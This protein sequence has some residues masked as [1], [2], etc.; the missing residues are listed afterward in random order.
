MILADIK[1][2]VTDIEGTTS[3]IHFVHQVLFPY[4]KQ[5][6]AD[7]LA[8]RAQEPAIQSQLHAV[9]AHTNW[10]DFEVNQA[11]CLAQIHDILQTWMAEDQ[12]IGALKALQGILWAEGYARGEFVTHF[13]PDA[14]VCLK[15]WFEKDLL[16]AVYSSRSV[17]AQQLLFGHTAQGDIQPWFSAWFDTAVGG[18]REVNAYVNIYQD[19]HQQAVN[20]LPENI[21]FLSDIAQELD[22]A[23]AAGWQTAHLVREG[24]HAA[25]STHWQCQSFAEIQLA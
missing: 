5:N 11:A 2:I 21:L 14:L 25:G 4:A 8:R 16:L 15:Q 17:Q 10:L 7:F 9:A 3:S 22:A 18:K 13:Y 1:A 6:M 19:L 20:L 23:R 12:K 24:N